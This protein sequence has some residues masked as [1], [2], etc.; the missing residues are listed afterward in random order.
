[1][2]ENY[3]LPPNLLFKSFLIVGGGY[4][5]T[6]LSW[7]VTYAVL[8]SIF[9]PKCVEFLS[10]LP[11]NSSNEDLFAEPDILMPMSLV[12]MVL[13]VHSITC[14]IVGFFISRISPFAKLNHVIFVAVAVYISFLQ[15][16]LGSPHEFLWK[17]I[18]MMGV[19]PIAI[20]LGAK[21]SGATAQSPV[22]ENLDEE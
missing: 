15:I 20:L 2:E 18:A 14:M 6:M 22:E 16:T 12:L 3:R 10:N 8:A 19:F 4:L 1:M 11:P 9:F 13:A 7:I 17:F 5:F 21:I